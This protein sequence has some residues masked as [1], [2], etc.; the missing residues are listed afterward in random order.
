MSIRAGDRLSRV[1]LV[2]SLAGYG[3]MPRGGVDCRRET[4]HL[5][6][7]TTPPYQ[8]KVAMK[9]QTISRMV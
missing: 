1:G 3:F 8:L 7:R 9:S 4:G 5:V 2:V 6:S